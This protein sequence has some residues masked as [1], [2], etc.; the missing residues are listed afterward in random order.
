MELV[1]AADELANQGHSIIH[2]SIGEPD[3]G[4]PPLV[5]E[6]FIDAIGKGRTGYTSALGIWPLREAISQFYAEKF[7]ATVPARNIV[8]TAGASS[9]LLF[10][11]LALIEKDDR[12]ILTDPGYPCNKTFVQTAGG[13]VSYVTPPASQGYQPVL[14]DIQKAWNENTKGAL[15]ASP[16]NPTG[17]RINNPDLQAIANWIQSKNG[18]LIVDEIYQS[19]TYHGDATSVLQVCDI[20]QKP[21]C[22]VNS[23]SKYFAMTGLRLGWL[24]VPDALLPAVEKFSQNLSICPNTP[25]QWAA[26]ACFNKAT[27]E[28]CEQRRQTFEER[29]DFMLTSLPTCGFDLDTQPDSAF[30]VYTAS[31]ASSSE[32]AHQL[33]Q[34][35]GVCVV[36]GIDFSAS[37]GPQTIRLSYANSLENIEKALEA[38]YRFNQQAGYIR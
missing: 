7:N 12:V 22:V 18:F 1:K 5:K 36:P 8:I 16:A 26:L 20:Q 35:T 27:L 10:A 32:Y 14:S 23:F 30:Y 2:L 33:L 34:E 9:A 29:L 3:F 31:P 38:I 6:A 28:L 17:T 11:C 13:K 25:T 24:V 19:L 15:L 37:H 4:V 21:V